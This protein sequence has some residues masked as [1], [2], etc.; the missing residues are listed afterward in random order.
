MIQPKYKLI[1]EFIKDKIESKKWSE[2]HKIPSETDL[3]TQFSASRMTARKAVDKVV[4]SG[5]LERTPSVGTFVKSIQ[6]QSSLLEIKNIADEILSRGHCHKM[7]VLSKLTMVPND[8]IAMSFSLPSK[9][10]YKIIVIH[11]ENDIPIQLEE[12]Y[13]NADK[14]PDF[15]HQDFSKITAHQY[16]ASVAPLT[17]AEISVEAVMPTKIL[18]HN[19][20][21]DNHIPCLKVTRST[22]SNGHPIS[23]VVLY[24]PADRFKLTTSYRL[25]E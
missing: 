14:V 12:R 9:I 22:Y 25:V 13:I 11:F 8:E 15:L 20:H 17:E 7:T 2:G 19:L 23:F 18:K 21:L 3:A 6:P 5:L 16:L 10:V 4:D 24:H 1:A